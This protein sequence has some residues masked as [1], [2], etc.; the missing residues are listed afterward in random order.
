MD[1]FVHFQYLIMKI[2]SAQ[3]SRRNLAVNAYTVSPLHTSL[4]V[5][6]LQR[7]KHEFACQSCKLVNMSGVH[8]HGCASSTNGCAFVYFTVQYGIEHSSTVSLFKPRMSRS[9]RKSSN[10]VA[11]TSVLFK[12]L[13]RFKMFYFLCLFLC[14]LWVKTITNLL[15]YSTVW[16][17]MLG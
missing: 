1:L 8:C 13:L 3:Q 17:V 11:G 6:N 12:V 14:I 5:G 4:Q 16:P 7:A 10:D 9:K 2:W 15:Q